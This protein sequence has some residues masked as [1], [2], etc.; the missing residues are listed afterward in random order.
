[1]YCSLDDIKKLRISEKRLLALTDDDNLGVVNEEKVNGIINGANEVIDGF[2]REKYSLPLDPVP[3]IVKEIALDICAYKLY[4]LR[5]EFE[6]PKTVVDVYQ[7][8]MKI[9]EQIQKDVIRLGSGAIG[10]PAT[11][12]PSDGLLVSSGAAIFSDQVLDKF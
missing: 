2:L 6:M 9:L 12:T 8:Q 10:T 1:M 3:G 5:P 4:A 11:E 7:A